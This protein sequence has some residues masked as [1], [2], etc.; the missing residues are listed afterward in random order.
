LDLG[1]RE[2]FYTLAEAK[3]SLEAGRPHYNIIGPHSS[4]SYCPLASASAHRQQAMLH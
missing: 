2:I 4:L 1:D 3:I